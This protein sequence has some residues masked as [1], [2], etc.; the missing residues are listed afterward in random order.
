MTESL[1]PSDAEPG[2]SHAG[3][4]L[5]AV[6]PSDPMF[7]RTVVLVLDHDEA[8]AL[9]LVLNRPG[10][11]HVADVL[12]EWAGAVA[13]PAVLFLGGPVTPEGAVCLGRSPAPESE[14]PPSLRP[15]AGG[16]VLV[17]LGSDADGPQGLPLDRLR[18][19]AG[20]SGWLPG[21]LDAE[22]AAGGW[23]VVDLLPGDPWSSAPE[24]LWRDVLRRQSGTMRLLSTFP[25]DPTL[26]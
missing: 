16:L 23:F 9:G 15:V 8:G 5:V 2:V 22:V 11:L 13:D 26:N 1:P 25:R 3:R 20:Y 6:P 14:L 12:P 18:V 7:D 21:Q 4:L 19:Y 24:L 17:D 10:D